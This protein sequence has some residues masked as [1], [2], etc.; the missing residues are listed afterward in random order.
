MLAAPDKNDKPLFAAKDIVDFYLNNCAEIFPQCCIQFLNPAWNLL[1]GLIGPRYNGK[2]L[3]SK[4]RELMGDK[5]LGQTLTKLVVPT[6]DIKLLQPICFSTYETQDIPLKNA[7]LADICIGT[8]AAPTYL[9]GHYFK[10]QDDQGNT[11]SF[12]LIDGGLAAD[13][14]TLVALNQVTKQ[15]MKSNKDFES[16]QPMDYSQ[17][18]VISIGTG[19]PKKAAWYSARGSAR[20]CMLQWVYNKGRTPLVDIFTEASSDMVDYHA[21]V[22]FKAQESEDR[23]LRI[24]D[25]NLTGNEASVDI[26]TKENLEKLV[27]IGEDLLEKPVSRVN[28]ETGQY[29]PVVDKYGRTTSNRERLVK[30]AKKLSKE[31]KLRHEKLASSA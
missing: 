5:K 17:F 9:P 10:T 23:Y 31:L 1:K 15:I 16:Y 13:N 4:I 27:K 8:S 11:R 14:P 25:D 6:F 18:L 30:F 26:S 21:S 19:A 7:R 3:R 2:T 24:Q 28:L 29:E 12:N 20:W 22:V